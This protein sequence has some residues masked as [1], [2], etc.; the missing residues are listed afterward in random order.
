VNKLT[1]TALRQFVYRPLDVRWV[2]DDPAWID[3]YRPTLQAIYANGKRMPSLVTIPSDHGAGPAVMHVDLL[4]DQHSFN[5]RGA[6]GVFSLWH[7]H[8]SGQALPDKRCPVKSGYRC[9]FGPRV[10][11]WLDSLS[12]ATSVQEAYDYILA[13]LSAPDYTEMHWQALENDFLRVP[14]TNDPAV[15]DDAADLGRRLRG[16][17]SL[18]VPRHQGVSWKGAASP[19]ALGK[20]AHSIDRLVFENGREL[21]GVTADA[22]AFETSNYPVLRSWFA[23]RTH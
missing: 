2:Y 18:N 4:M 1:A 19:E 14:L 20:A 6:K 12:R 10:H 5:N 22:W 7:P 17:W 13:V 11:D 8:N 23:A 3:W 15:F 21:D 16:A 9:G